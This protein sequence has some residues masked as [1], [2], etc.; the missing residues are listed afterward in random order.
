MVTEATAEVAMSLLTVDL[1]AEVLLFHFQRESSCLSCWTQNCAK[2]CSVL[3]RFLLVPC[4]CDFRSCCRQ[5]QI[6]FCATMC[7][8]A[9]S[10]LCL[11]VKLIFELEIQAKLLNL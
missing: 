11:L 9:F 7:H 4:A 8:L 3:F 6:T 5:R 10:V 1:A 2:M